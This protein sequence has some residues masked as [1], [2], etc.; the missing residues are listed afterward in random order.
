MTSLLASLFLFF[1]FERE[2]MHYV[3]YACIHTLAGWSNLLKQADG[4]GE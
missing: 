3:C 2:Y 1:G 4:D